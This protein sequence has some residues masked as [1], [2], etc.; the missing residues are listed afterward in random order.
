MNKFHLLFI[1]I[2]CSIQSFKADNEEC[3]ITKYSKGLIINGVEVQ[4]G[5]FPFSIALL[6][7]DDDQDKNE[8]F[9]GGCLITTKHALTGT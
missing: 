4:K 8:Y 7:L 6:K 9:C 1:L 3:G 5:E 2:F